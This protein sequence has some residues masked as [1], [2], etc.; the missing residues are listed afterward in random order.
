ML[1]IENFFDFILVTPE[2]ANAIAAFAAVFIS[3]LSVI[4]ALWAL[5]VQR[6]HNR[7][8]VRPLAFI[9]RADYEGRLSVKIHNNG[10]GPLIITSLQVSDGK[11]I[12]ESVIDCMTSLPKNI[13][14]DDFTKDLKSRSLAPGG[15][16]VLLQLSGDKSDP[17]FREVRDRCRE[18]LRHLTNKLEYQDIYEQPMKP[19]EREL[20]WFGR[21]GSTKSTG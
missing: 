9:S 5:A 6:R 8:S 19:A 4:L 14:W 12:Q 13:M 7:L 17:H 18:V 11:T 10:V 3:F 16:I 15:E 21:H 20:S 2:V 1:I